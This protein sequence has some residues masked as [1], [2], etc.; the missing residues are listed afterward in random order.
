MN[1]FCCV[2][3]SQF[4]SIISF[5]CVDLSQIVCITSFRCVH[6]S[7]FFCATSFYCIHLPQLLYIISFRCVH[8]LQFLYIYISFHRVHLSQIQSISQPMGLLCK[9]QSTSTPKCDCAAHIIHKVTINMFAVRFGKQ[10]GYVIERLLLDIL[11][12][13]SMLLEVLEIYFKYILFVI[14]F[15]TL[16]KSGAD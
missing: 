2:H 14:T 10:D 1:S 3:L 4:L 16:T 5:H 6:L 11:F 15:I 13:L 12:E 7:H 8:S 9:S